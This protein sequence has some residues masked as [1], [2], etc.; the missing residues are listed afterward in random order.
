MDLYGTL[1]GMRASFK[2]KVLS[3]DYLGEMAVNEL[4]QTNVVGMQDMRFQ[5]VI[6]KY[7]INS[8]DGVMDFIVHEVTQNPKSNYQGHSADV[9]FLQEFIM[10]CRR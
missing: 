6:N 3:Q 8:S 4:L 1:N 10:N 7:S 2:K 9:S 5:N